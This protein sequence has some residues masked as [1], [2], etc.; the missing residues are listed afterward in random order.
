[1]N[2]FIYGID[3]VELDCKF[4]HTI[5]EMKGILIV[6]KQKSVACQCCGQLTNYYQLL[7]TRQRYEQDEHD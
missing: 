2:I 6:V 7:P 3:C 1:M 5:G 4:G